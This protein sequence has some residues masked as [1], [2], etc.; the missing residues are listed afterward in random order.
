MSAKNAVGLSLILWRR[1]AISLRLQF[2]SWML[3]T[4]KRDSSV[5]ILPLM[6]TW[7]SKHST[8]LISLLKSLDFIECPLSLRFEQM[9]N[10]QTEQENISGIGSSFRAS[11]CFQLKIMKC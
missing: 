2:L 4:A 6:A 11:D 7:T 3:I 10:S 9:T 8:H 5:C 1:C